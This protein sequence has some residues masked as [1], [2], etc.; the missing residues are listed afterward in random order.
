MD[1]IRFGSDEIDQVL[2]K[3]GRRRLDELPFGAILLD[4]RGNIIH[5]NSTESA[6]SGRS[7]DDVIGKNFFDDIAPCTNV[8][9]FRRKF[10]EGVR[11]R[12]FNTLFEMVF[13]QVMSPTRVRVH[14]KSADDGNVW[15][16]TKRI[17]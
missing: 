6:I 15:I 13:D 4:P 14:M 9:E 16:F 2:S 11:S 3:L 17:T 8:P 12:S 5:Y 7:A 1:N 10:D